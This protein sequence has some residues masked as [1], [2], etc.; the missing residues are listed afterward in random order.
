MPGHISCDAVIIDIFSFIDNIVKYKIPG[1]SILAFYIYYSPTILI[2]VTPM[3]AL[4][5]TIYVLSNLNKTSE[6]TAMKA[7]GISLWRVLTPILVLGI[8]ISISTFIVNDKVIPTSSKIA[9]YIRE[10]EL[11]KEKRKNEQTKI[12]KNVAVYGSGNRII[13]ARSYDTE[14][15]VLEDIIIHKHDGKENLISKV[16]A[17]KG[18]WTGKN[19]KFYK[20]IAYKINNSGIFLGEPIFSEERVIPIREK[21]SD[22]ANKEW[23][24]EY[25]SYRQ[26]KGYMRH[27][28]GAGSRL[29]KSLLVDLYYKVAFP[30]ISFVIIIVG[31]PFALITTRGGVL[32]GIGMSICIGLLYYA[33]IAIALAF[34]K[35]GLIPPAAAAWSGNIIFLLLGIY[36]MNKRA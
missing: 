34:G 15:K 30:F 26:L 9:T 11:E 31:A 2:Q 22:F 19:W 28:A 21:P 14:K 23:R 17:E 20:V 36:L 29:I 33:F 27:F 7:C 25:L 32:I 1:L 12:I 16:T 24:S 35:A 5:S 3:A 6:I 4:L 13:F 18:E 10:N 8:I